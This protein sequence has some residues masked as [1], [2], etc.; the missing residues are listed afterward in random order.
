MFFQNEHLETL[1][2]S[3]LSSENGV[4]FD[5][6][7]VSDGQQTI[8]I[9]TEEGNLLE[10][11]LLEPSTATLEDVSQKSAV[12]RLL[13]EAIAKLELDNE[14]KK[15]TQVEEKKEM[16]TAQDPIVQVTPR[17]IKRQAPP[18]PAPRPSLSQVTSSASSCKQSEA[19]ESESGLSTLPKVS[20]IFNKW[21]H[22]C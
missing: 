9:A 10:Q 14:S 1:F 13:E 21:I 5:I 16:D 6:T 8:E 2:Y 3:W 15:E 20:D 18:V 7:S 19:E 17:R 11:P 12:E 22:E 4:Q